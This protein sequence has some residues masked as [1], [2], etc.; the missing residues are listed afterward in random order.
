MEFPHTENNIF[1]S[2][3]TS[4]NTPLLCKK[5]PPT[6][7]CNNTFQV[8]A[9]GIYISLRQTEIGSL[10]LSCLA[11]VEIANKNVGNVVSLFEA[12]AASH[13]K[14]FCFHLAFLLM[15]YLY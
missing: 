13:A 2:D 14:Y 15:S 3:D 9:K 1:R 11:P 5:Q 7:I 4:G 12:A 8:H 6:F 10:F